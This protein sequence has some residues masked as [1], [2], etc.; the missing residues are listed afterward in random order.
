MCVIYIRSEVFFF[1]S[2]TSYPT[3][4]LFVRER[5]PFLYTAGRVSF[6]GFP[7]TTVYS[8]TPLPRTRHDTAFFYFGAAS[9]GKT[10][11]L[12]YLPSLLRYFS[13]WKR[14]GHSSSRPPASRRDSALFFDGKC[15]RKK[16]QPIVCIR[17]PLVRKQNVGFSSR[18]QPPYILIIILLQ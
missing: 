3:Y 10:I 8:S 1:Y 17:R 9:V 16:S 15:V 12:S 7:T 4:E 14:F 5:V 13:F 2:A 18:T 11:S 6:S